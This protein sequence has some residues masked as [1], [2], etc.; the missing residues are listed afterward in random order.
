MIVTPLS[1]TT[2]WSVTVPSTLPPLA[3]AMSTITLPGFIEA[4]ISAVMSRGAGLPG[5]SAVVM[6]MSTS[7]A[8]SAYSCRLAALVVLAHL[9]G[10]A[11]GRHL[12]L[13]RLDRTGTRRPATDLL[14][15]LGPRVGGAHD[16][17][18]A[19][20]RADGGETGDAGAD[21]E[22][23]G[24]RHLARRG[25]LAGEEPAELVGR[26]DD[27]A[28]AGDVGHR[29]QHVQRLRAGD[30]RHGVHGQHRDRRRG[31]LST[32]RGSAPARSG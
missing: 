5:I 20:G 10:V 29:R 4:T 21:D 13:L 23:L 2:T 8:C 32:S 7:L 15:D 1:V 17:A 25:D 11:V 9:L 22:H 16:G 26:L 6:M 18:Q 19:A 28:V 24:R 12:G 27:G 3:A 30:P 14:G 31:Q